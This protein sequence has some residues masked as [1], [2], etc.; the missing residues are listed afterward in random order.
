MFDN[1]SIF[2]NIW[3]KAIKELN[4]DSLIGIKS[5][6]IARY[7][8]EDYNE[9]I[10]RQKIISDLE[11][12]DYLF[13]VF[14]RLIVNIETI[15]SIRKKIESID[16]VERI[17][18]RI[19]DTKVFVDCVEM[20]A[21]AYEKFSTTLQSKRLSFYLESYYELSKTEKFTG[22]KQYIL[23]F[24]TVI[25]DIKS[26]NLAVNLNAEFAPTE[27]GIISFNKEFYLADN[28]FSRVFSSSSSPHPV[29]P[30]VKYTK[31][32]T[33]LDNSIYLSINDYIKKALKKK[34]TELLFEFESMTS[35]FMEIKDEL[36]FLGKCV[37]FIKQYRMIGAYFSFPKTGEKTSI[38]G[39]YNP[40]L[41]KTIEYNRIVKNDISFSESARIIILTGANAG[42][43]SIY[44]RTVGIIQL[45]FQL[46]MPVP[47]FSAIIKTRDK[48]F[49]DF[50]KKNLE[51]SESSFVEECKLVRTIIDE[52]GSNSMILFDEAF[53]S[54]SS[55]DGSEV[56]FN[57]L[58]FIQKKSAYCLFS[59]HLHELSNYIDKLNTYGQT[60]IPAHVDVSNGKRT[61]KV[62]LG[63]DDGFSH[64]FDI[65]RR[66]GLLFLE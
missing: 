62:I 1:C 2:K 18:Y 35:G 49:T 52:I 38:E 64:A 31:E 59:T 26:I 36:L 42:G 43:K 37:Q 29:T 55:A 33:A 66:Y 15:N 57:V 19:R 54:T 6:I 61:Y 5:E 45:F 53:S 41:L 17:L 10:E 16:S 56:A 24:D 8:T 32:N 40:L 4:F 58:R 28:I 46:G 30:L 20:L 13:D 48:L 3:E 21:T 22:V 63:S 11:K 65:A 51:N 47:A 25:C 50:S 23:E 14:S 39:A 34:M 9:I 12:N 44:L 27:I 60:V 7:I